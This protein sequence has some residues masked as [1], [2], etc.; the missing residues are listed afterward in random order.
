[1]SV[2]QR[3]KR[4]D[5]RLDRASRRPEAKRDG[6]E[7]PARAELVGH[8][9]RVAAVGVG[10]EEPAVLVREHFVRGQEALLGEQGREQAGKRTARLVEL[11][12]RR[13]PLREG[14]GR[15]AAGQTE[16]IALPLGVETE[17]LACRRSAAEGTDDAGRVPPSGAKRRI[18]RAEADTHRGLEAGRSEERRVGKE[19]RSRWSPYH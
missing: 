2:D 19:C 4:A 10:V 11:D 6:L 1:M 16:G 15:L 5:D 13:A 3:K 18:V 7:L 12:R 9:L 8:R 14:A 17:Q